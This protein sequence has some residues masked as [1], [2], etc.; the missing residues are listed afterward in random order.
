MPSPINLP[1]AAKARSR[2][3][4]DTCDTWNRK[5]HYFVGLYFLFFLW[6]FAFTGLLLNHSSWTFAEFWPN[7]KVS[8]FERR[9]QRHSSSG[10]LEQARDMMRQ[11][12]IGGEIEWITARAD[13]AR[14]EFR[15]NRPGQ[16]FDIKADLEQG[17]VTVSRTEVNAWGIMRIL[18]TTGART[19]DAKRNRIDRP[20]SGRCPW[21][22]WRQAW[23][24]CSGLVR[25]PNQSGR[26]WLLWGWG[27]QSGGS[28]GLH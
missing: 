1:T 23:C 14:L 15:A 21:M 28:F 18:H 20:P 3:L 26:G 16:N 8:T 10:D 11:L 6:L 5:L 19:G 12:G 4:A 27:R 17:R 2:R 13:N 25:A 22:R 24:S 9:I 7:R